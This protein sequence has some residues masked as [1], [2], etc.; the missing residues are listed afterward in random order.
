MADFRVPPAGRGNLQ[1]GSKN[2]I[3]RAPPPT[4]LINA[5]SME[6]NR[7]TLAKEV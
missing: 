5:L 6:Y 1:E 2:R 4:P 3:F 7:D